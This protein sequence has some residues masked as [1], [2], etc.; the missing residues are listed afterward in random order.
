ME[1]QYSEV[2]Q[3]NAC[4]FNL[5]QV[6]DLICSGEK[7]MKSITLK[8]PTLHR[9]CIPKSW[10]EWC[11]IYIYIFFFFLITM[12]IYIYTYI[13]SFSLQCWSVYP[14]FQ[15]SLFINFLL[16]SSAQFYSHYS[17]IKYCNCDYNNVHI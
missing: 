4:G 12:C 2:N 15:F 14:N 17:S 10:H 16:W 1:A 8:F 11:Y 3:S 5:N 7:Q 6:L 9:W 13:F